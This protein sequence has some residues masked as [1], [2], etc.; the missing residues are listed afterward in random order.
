MIK[1]AQKGFDKVRIVSVKVIR[2][3]EDFL[4]QESAGGV[5]LF[6]AM[7]LALGWVNSPWS[8]Y[9]ETIFKTK[10]TIGLGE[11]LLSKPLLLWINDGLMAIFFLVVGLEIKREI[12]AGELSSVR[13]SILPIGAAF[14]GMIFPALVF[15]FFNIGGDTAK[16]WGIPM[17]TDIAFALGCVSLLSKRVP[18]TLALFLTAVAIVDDIGAVLVIALFYTADISLLALGI[19]VAVFLVLFIGNR[20]RI[21]QVAFYMVLGVLLWVAVLKSGVHATIA[22]VVLGMVIPLD[23]NK[24][25]ASVLHK[26]EHSLHPWVTYFIMPVFA[27]ANAGVKID[28]GSVGNLI[29]SPVSLGIILGL[30]L[31]KQFGITV[32]S[33]LMVKSKLAVLPSGLRW[34]H[35]YGASLLG[36]IGFTMSL[37]IAGLAFGDEVL[38][39]NAKIAIL[40]GSFISAITGIVVLTKTSS[41]DSTRKKI[42]KKEQL[43]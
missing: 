8:S 6:I 30:F 36:G 14:G 32:A 21:Q 40:T 19:A 31:G 29:T 7:L 18:R 3:F 23:T 13:K 41:A 9:Y 43:A 26:L 25:E 33:Y 37:F 24:P 12:V 1:R 42:K 2:P 38:L 35:I 15:L 20:L 10:F 34:N 22:G 11:H 17:A 5:I 4:R 16:G 39:A 28:L 27:L